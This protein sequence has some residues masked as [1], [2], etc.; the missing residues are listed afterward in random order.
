[1]KGVK[2][3]KGKIASAKHHFLDLRETGLSGGK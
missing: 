1:M 3:E 2:G